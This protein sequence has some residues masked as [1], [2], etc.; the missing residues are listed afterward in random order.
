MAIER[1]VEHLIHN[2]D[3]TIGQRNSYRC[4]PRRR[5]GLALRPRVAIEDLRAREPYRVGRRA[6]VGSARAA[7][8]RSPLAHLRLPDFRDS[9][10]ALGEVRVAILSAG[11]DPQTR[12]ASRLRGTRRCAG[13]RS[14]RLRARPTDRSAPRLDR[15]AGPDGADNARRGVRR[16]RSRLYRGHKSSTAR[17]LLAAK[18]WTM[19]EY[20]NVYAIP[21][22][23]IKLHLL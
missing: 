19:S 10:T 15:R 11:P 6:V 18:R 7:W 9:L 1:R 12:R 16:V 3:G 23:H 22:R 4:D 13:V 21:L 2:Q 17:P 20:V 5:K 8:P 14:R